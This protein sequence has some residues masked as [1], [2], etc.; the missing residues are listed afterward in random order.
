MFDTNFLKS[1]EQTKNEVRPSDASTKSATDTGVPALFECLGVGGMGEVYRCG[2]DALGRDLAVKILKAELRG[3]TAAEER[4]LREARLTGSLQHPAIVPIHHL[5]RLADGRPCYTMKLV[6]G[7]T[8]AALLRDEPAG[9]ERLPRLLAVLEKVCQAVAFAHSKGVLHRDLKP[10]NIMVGEF[11]E[12]Q[13]M[14]WGLAKELPRDRS[15][16]TARMEEEAG[17]SLA[18]VTLGTPH[19]MPPEQA[20]GDWNIVDERADVFALGAILCETL[21]GRPPY[22]GIS[23]AEVLEGSRSGDTAKAL[24]RLEQCEVDPALKKLCR[25][26]LAAEPQERPRH[27][28]VVAERLASYQAEVRERLRR[29]ELEQ[30]RAE[31]T[32]REERKRRRLRATLAVVGLLLLAVG[33]AAGWLWQRR[34][35]E[36]DGAVQ[37]ALSEAR[38]P[39]QQAGDGPLTALAYDQALAAARKADSIARTAGASSAMQEQASACLVKLQEEAEE[40]AKD[41]QLLARLLEVRGPREGPKYR[42]DDKGAMMALAEPTAE[43]Q[44]ASAFRDWGLDVDAAS[45]VEAAAR[46]KERPAAMVTEVIAALDEWAIQRQLDGKPEAARRVVELAAA[47]DDDPGSRRRELR[48]ILARDQLPKERALALL[49][50]ALRPVPVPVVV[51]VGAD[52]LRLRQLAEQMDPAEEPVLVV[53]TLTRALW[54]AGEEA[55][56]ERVLRTAVIARP[57][58]VVLY[59]TLGQVLIEQ[60]PP[61]W[62][63]AARFLQAAR[64]LRPDLG[65][66]LATALLHSGQDD[67]GLTLLA[68]LAIQSPQNPYLH[69]QLAYALQ[70]KARVDEAMDEFR[71]VIALDPKLAIAH[72]NLGIVLKEKGRV[73]EAMGEYRQA[74]ALDPKYAPAHNNLGVVLRNNK[75]RADEALDEFRRAIALD[76]RLAPAHY[77]LG[78]VLQEKGRGDEAMIEFHQTIALEP[79]YAPAHYNLGVVLHDKGRADEALVEYRE[80]IALDPKLAV[81]HFNLANVLRDKGRVD[82]AMVAYRQAIVLDPKLAMAHNNLGVIL[83]TK[84][85]R[86]DEAM[87]EFCQAIALDPKLAIAHYNLG[88]VLRQKGRVDEALVAYHQAIAHNP[89]Y[90]EAYCNLGLVLQQQG[91]FTESLAAYRRGHELGSKQSAWGYP[92]LQWVHAAERLV[93]LENKLPA[94]LQGEAS[95]VHPGDAITLA[96]M[97]RQH[98]KLHASAAR[99]YTDAFAAEPK[100]AADLNQQHRY[101][102]ACSAA[103]AAAGQ[104]EDAR[105]L[106]DKAAAMFRRWAL[107]W[108]RDD[109]RT[110]A[111]DAEQNNAALKQTIQH[112]LVQW[113][114][115]VALAAVREAQAL[116]RLGD[117]E[118]AAWQALWRDVDE[119]RTR[120]AK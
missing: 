51:P 22:Q 70:H 40:A 3:D 60:E 41:R 85:G 18:G 38:L 37:S 39:R 62:G 53:L 42:P 84:K 25:A 65:V 78:V 96:W 73:D 86:V 17:L 12:V 111:R 99:L 118:R 56:A 27:A 93:E 119:L 36:A 14:D 1:L 88:N 81:A 33:G 8:L 74:I 21:T 97:C 87:V 69:F 59:H 52:H 107:N 63:E 30:A 54:A 24:R 95:P 114:R 116:D 35:A 105:L 117:N 49:S 46:L 57:R 19:Y 110:Y 28:G 6:R 47:L 82:E 91:R 76:A 45:A 80:V 72:Y 4:F 68:R 44:F 83:L 10:A 103:L 43:E 77:N 92:S 13:V 120:V 15:E 9:P 23:C 102:A 106:S 94:F 113:R 71:R 67:E 108:L 79:K 61:R 5:G 58:E 20:A 31:V 100:L 29:A 109:L 34:R 112:R 66:A 98:K 64:S 48:A 16:T 101:H 2:D 50:A 32:A 115:D 11:G 55:L 104:G 75:G 7:R 90:A 89:K 26:C